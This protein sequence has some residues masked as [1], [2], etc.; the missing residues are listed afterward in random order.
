MSNPV[1]RFVI[2]CI[3]I[4]VAAADAVLLAALPGLSWN[5]VAKAALIALGNALG[6]AGIGAATPVEPSVKIK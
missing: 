1:V 5:D 3:F 6:Y 2:R 4:G